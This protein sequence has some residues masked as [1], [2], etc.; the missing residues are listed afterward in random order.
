M[1]NNS[2]R[3]LLLHDPL[4]EVTRKERRMLLGVS[5]VGVAVQ[6]AG[7]VPSKISALGIEFAKSD[8]SA[9]LS[10]LAL[11]V[12]YFLTAFIVYGI[13]DFMAWRR[14]LRR[15]TLFNIR[16]KLRRELEF[17]S[18]YSEKERAEFI[19]HSDLRGGFVLYR[20]SGHIS[21]IRAIFEFLLPILVGC[22]SAYI[23][24][25]SDLLSKNV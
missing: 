12:L 13:S 25:Y 20:L 18:D 14:A 6:K 1:T 8:Q 21:A 5:I 22:Y 11:V 15:Q 19:R 10:L 7:L 9:I 17:G 24:L 23:L 2:E 3:D 4:S 16:E